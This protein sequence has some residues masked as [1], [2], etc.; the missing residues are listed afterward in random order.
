MKAPNFSYHHVRSSVDL[1]CDEDLSRSPVRN[2]NVKDSKPNTTE[3][4]KWISD[5]TI[6]RR[7]IRRRTHCSNLL[8][9]AILNNS[10]SKAKKEL[11]A[12]QEE[13][14]YKARVF[15]DFLMKNNPNSYSDDF[16]R[17]NNSV[18]EEGDCDPQRLNYNY[19]H[20]ER[21]SDRFLSDEDDV[22]SCLASIDSFF[23]ELKSVKA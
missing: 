7:I 18:Q 2:S 4:L 20:L 6:K 19:S 8:A 9:D 10:L 15:A 16:G 12:K 13:K 5:V 23:D 11:A 17:D 3:L 21:R 1:M 22:D 14:R